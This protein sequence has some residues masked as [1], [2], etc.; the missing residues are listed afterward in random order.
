MS[1]KNIKVIDNLVGFNK[2]RVLSLD[3]NMIEKIE[4]LDHLTNLEWLDLSFNKI[5]VI[6]G[7]EK[8]TKL[9]DLSLFNNSIAK[10]ENL[11]AC[12]N[13]NCLSLGNNR[14]DD[15]ENLMYLRRFQNLRSVN[16]HGNPVSEDPEY[17]FSVLAFLKHIKYLDYALVVADE[18]VEANEHHQ[19][20]LLELHETENM[21][22]T[23]ADRKKANDAIVE[24]LRSANLL[25]C[26]T[27]LTD[28]FKED[29][30][31][32]KLIL[33]P[34]INLLKEEF[35]E[36]F[37]N[38]FA[39]LKTI[40]LQSH[41]EMTTEHEDIVNTIEEAKRKKHE[42]SVAIIDAFNK[43]KKR[44]F[45]ELTDADDARSVVS[46][47]EGLKVDLDNMNEQL[48]ELE[49][50]LVEQ[51]QDIIDAFDTN[52]NKLATAMKGRFQDFFQAFRDIHT[53][54]AETITNLVHELYEKFASD[55]LSGLDEEAEAL[56]A[57][58]E[59]LSGLASTS[60]ELQVAKLDV[61]ET[62]VL[63]H[64]K[65]ST[66]NVLHQL[67]KDENGRNRSRVAEIHQL[68]ERFRKEIQTVLSEEA[69]EEEEDVEK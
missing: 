26:S 9:S 11:D 13:L 4:H 39:N 3:N 29:T 68:V 24:N 19:D 27:V 52:Y 33:L 14:I 65:E 23:I 16:L 42:Q 36:K 67:S 56:F 8:L 32:P 12:V 5:T 28:M 50:E 48:M 38:L 43:K 57:D 37:N 21:D 54:F 66:D 47:L 45:R 35:T 53:A 62:E 61:R 59:V 64:H 6:E 40:G 1:F 25:G 31:M 58:K 49:M 51:M 30:E 7:L 17:K 63:K 22:A 10:I 46:Q 34:G 41:L 44:I 18:V 69:F 20:R 60:S 15:L 2:L 55:A